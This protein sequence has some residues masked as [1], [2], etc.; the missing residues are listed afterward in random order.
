MKSSY[1]KMKDT[2]KKEKDYSTQG[3]QVVPNLTTN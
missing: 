2:A 3:S 1:S